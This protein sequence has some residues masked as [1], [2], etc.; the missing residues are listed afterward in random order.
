MAKSRDNIKRLAEQVRK[1][2]E[3]SGTPFAVLLGSG[4]SLSPEYGPMREMVGQV[5]E[6]ALP[7]SPS[8]REWLQACD[9]FR[10]RLGGISDARTL[11]RLLE[12][13]LDQIIEAEGYRTLARLV[14]DGYVSLVLTVNFDTL[15]E[16]ALEDELGPG[17]VKLIVGRETPETLAK[18]LKEEKRPVVLKV[19]GDFPSRLFMFA[20][21]RRRDAAE[22]LGR[23]PFDGLAGGLIVAGWTPGDE[24]WLEPV[25][26]F[27]GPFWFANPERPAGAVLT[28]MRA[29]EKRLY[30]FPE[31][32]VEGI[33]GEFNQFFRA[34]GE[35][36]SSAGGKAARLA[37]AGDA[38]AAIQGLLERLDAVEGRLSRRCTELLGSCTPSSDRFLRELRALA[39]AAGSLRGEL[40]EESLRFRFA[41]MLPA[42]EAR[43]PTALVEGV[44]RLEHRLGAVDLAIRSDE[45]LS[46]ELS[47]GLVQTF[48]DPELLGREKLLAQARNRLASARVFQVVGDRDVGRTTFARALPGTFKTRPWRW[49]L[50]TDVQPGDD[51]VSVTQRMRARLLELGVTAFE[52]ACNDSGL[53]LREV[54]SALAAILRET[55]TFWIIDRLEHVVE[56][57]RFTDRRLQTF[58]RSLTEERLG[59]SRLIWVS[60]RRLPLGPG[61]RV[62]HI[63]VGG[64]EGEPCRKLLSRSPRLAALEA[65]QLDTLAG[66]C[67]GAPRR[68]LWVAALAERREEP[69]LLEQREL[70]EDPQALLKALVEALPEAWRRLLDRMALFRLPVP[71]AAFDGAAT[72]VLEGLCA[73]GLVEAWPDSRWRVVPP[74]RWLLVETMDASRLRAAHRKAARFYRSVP[75][76]RDFA[77]FALYGLEALIHQHAVGDR[78]GRL[79]R[80]LLSKLQQN[81]RDLYAARDHGGAQKFYRLILEL[82]PHHADAHFH[83][84]MLASRRDDDPQVAE[85]HLLA[86]LEREP[87][88]VRFCHG[89]GNHYRKVGR[90]DEAAEMYSRAIAVNPRASAV[91]VAFAEL[92]FERGNLDQ[93]RRIL[94]SALDHV[95][96]I[97]P[98][99]EA[100]ARIETNVGD[101]TR[102]QELLTRL[103]ASDK[104]PV[105]AFAAL[106]Q[107]HWD[108]GDLAAAIR[109]LEEGRTRHPRSLRLCLQLARCLA[110]SGQA[111]SAREVMAQ[112]LEM[113]PKEPTALYQAGIMA[114]AAGDTE[115]A[116]RRLSTLLKQR[117][118]DPRPAM[119]L[120][121]LEWLEGRRD[122]AAAAFMRGLKI[123]PRHTVLLTC[124]ALLEAERREY[125][126]A[127]EFVRRAIRSSQGNR[128]LL[129]LRDSLRNRAEVRKRIEQSA[130]AVAGDD[131]DVAALRRHARLLL[132]N[133]YD[134]EARDTFVR[135]AAA[136]EDNVSVL[137]EIFRLDAKI[138]AP[139]ERTLADME[140]ALAAD[141]EDPDTICS[142]ARYLATHGGDPQRVD[143]LF[144]QAL[145]LRPD[146]YDAVRHYANW[147][148]DNGRPEDAEALY[149]QGI[150]LRPFEALSHN[151]LGLFYQSL[152]H[153]E[154]A[155]SL[156]RKAIETTPGFA[157]PY[158]SLSQVLIAQKRFE[159]VPAL[160]L[161][162]VSQFHV[163][164]DFGNA[165]RAL[166]LLAG[167]RGEE[168]FDPGM[169]WH[170]A[171]VAAGLELLAR[172]DSRRHLQPWRRRLLQLDPPPEA[173]LSLPAHLLLAQLRSFLAD[174]AAPFQRAAAQVEPERAKELVWQLRELGNVDRKTREAYRKKI[175]AAAVT[176][177]DKLAI[178]TLLHLRWRSRHIQAAMEFPLIFP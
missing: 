94:D 178:Q 123:D 153:Y 13:H 152:G 12:R 41:R 144:R 10:E 172:L 161:K 51:F 85:K 58:L 87:D 103:V 133:G 48:P 120:G 156:F 114:W 149:I 95:E 68:L 67:R 135:I 30:G 157:W 79:P 112:A 78:A 70:V 166:E 20:E 115:E 14:A 61:A 57:G 121:M 88:S 22:I 64:L 110:D 171:V 174:S 104:A 138:G 23:I 17:Y 47:A 176:P 80:G 45:A 90:L 125:K 24:I 91:H 76:G 60:E 6:V 175:E 92:E 32:F 1:A 39:G 69:S 117:R 62:E 151:N 16:R 146:H 82:S 98:I 134:A 158:L 170:A 107:L 169:A 177:L 108:L 40:Q 100:Y 29:K 162:A 93:A 132:D 66:W 111:E 142:A 105:T 4:A 33:Y 26:S 77:R 130:A 46:G 137:K 3:Q 75:G 31:H 155:E 83:L 124:C 9:R 54:G 139:V 71:P 38:K 160:V 15:L 49:I 116:R 150:Q 35:A 86:A 165:A 109:T 119:A 167:L 143:A 37:G 140:A 56:G 148:K 154:R 8:R 101:P 126:R 18:R 147:L 42:A 43:I 50:H 52:R 136:T 63:V 84:G 163:A 99:L 25:S 129:K 145:E 72:E 102:A 74:L 27:S 59:D 7:E 127:L 97:Q 168:G 159:E 164:R 11:N 21:R 44:E 128:S 106:A 53:T 28:H 36:L 19:C 73:A 131:A 55:P 96:E 89:L 113:A 173:G 2:R 5:A 141:P 118:R 34:L 122:E 65:E 81:A